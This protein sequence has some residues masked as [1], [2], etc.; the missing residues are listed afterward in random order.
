MTRVEQLQE[1]FANRPLALLPAFARDPYMSRK[2]TAPGLAASVAVIPVMGVLTNDQSDWGWGM[3]SYGDIRRAYI[4]ALAADDVAAIALLIDSP[5]GTVAGCFD[6]ADLIF[7]SRGA[8]PTHA[9]LAET[10]YSGAYA[11]ASAADT[12]SVPRT[13]GTGS[14]GVIAMHVDLT[15]ALKQAGV[16]VTVLRFGDRK[17]LGMPV[18]PFS[19][20]AHDEVMAEVSFAGELFIDTV[21]RNRGLSASAVRDTEGG[22][23]IGAAGIAAGFADS[24]AA[25]DAA[26][27]ALLDALS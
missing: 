12:I 9:I 16:K 21:A 3:Q 25:P 14:V 18:E 10:A 26:F 22:C 8:K 19:D 5:G 24:L 2:G 17:A 13:G 20:A 1:R 11:L 6:L 15:G 27:A 23:F 4:A 7:A